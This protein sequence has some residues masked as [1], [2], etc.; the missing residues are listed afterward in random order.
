MLFIFD[1]L[2]T[3]F[4]ALYICTDVFSQSFIINNWLLLISNDH[5]IQVFF[6]SK[7][8]AYK[9]ELITPQQFVNLIL[10]YD[11]Q[12]ASYIK[13]WILWF[14]PLLPNTFEKIYTYITFRT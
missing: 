9:F 13:M 12:V 1:L 7:S 10:S 11:F 6:F 2:Q 8:D 14:I 3:S 4:K 5:L